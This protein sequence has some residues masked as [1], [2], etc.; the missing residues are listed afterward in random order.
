MTTTTTPKPARSRVKPTA[1]AA[2]EATT[3]HVPADSSTDATEAPE[4]AHRHASLAE[5]LAAFQAEIPTVRKG[6]TADVKSDRGSYSYSYADL[7]DI[8]EKAMPLL[9]K[10]G[11]SFTAKPTFVADLG[12]VLV[13]ELRHDSGDFDGGTYPLPNPSTPA[14]QMGSAITYARR[15]TLCSVTGIAPGGDDDDAGAIQQLQYG[16]P[17]PRQQQQPPQQRPT[18]VPARDWAAEAQKLVDDG[19][20]TKAT[21]GGMWQ[22]ARADGAPLDVLDRIAAL[23][24]VQ[25]AKEDQDTAAEGSTTPADADAPP[26]EADAPEPGDVADAEAH[27]AEQRVLDNEAGV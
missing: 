7:S 14:Q 4:R 1:D 19:T 26:T 23:G 24:R 9:G 6:N 25:A 5:A 13:Y 22:G 3:D 18:S 2:P 16:P 17:Q 12:F 10:H 15:Y 21:L 11:L 27:L 8:T 20:A